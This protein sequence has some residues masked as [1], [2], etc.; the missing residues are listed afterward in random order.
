[1]VAEELPDTGDWELVYLGP[2]VGS[3]NS[4]RFLANPF[5]VVGKSIRPRSLGRSRSVPI[6][7]LNGSN[8]SPKP[9]S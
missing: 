1:M 7:R 5:C 3:T 4:S 2:K 6:R 9:F 8:V